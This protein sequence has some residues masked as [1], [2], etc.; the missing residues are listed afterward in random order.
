MTAKW[1]GRVLVA[2]S[3][4]FACGVIGFDVEEPIPEQV[5]E[6]SPI[7]ALLPVSLFEFPLQIDIESKTR[8]MDTGPAHS[9]QLKAITLTVLVPAGET[10]EFLD[11]L[12]IFVAADGLERREVAKLEEVPPSGSISLQIVPGVDLLPYVE[13]GATLSAT[14]TGH[15]PRQTI[16]FAG[17]VVVTIKV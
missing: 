9:A 4:L 8:A 13:K 5:V 6:G 15:M 10:F 16:R 11:S 7:G 12:R 14:A 2:S 1:Q 17:K 3:L